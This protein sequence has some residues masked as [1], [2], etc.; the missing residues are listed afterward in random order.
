MKRSRACAFAA[1]LLLVPVM[2]G[3]TGSAAD[4]PPNVANRLERLEQTVQALSEENA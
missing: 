1:L 3:L 4:A 2:Y